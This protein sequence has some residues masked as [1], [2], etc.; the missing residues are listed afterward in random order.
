MAAAREGG[1]GDSVDGGR[2]EEEKTAALWV[3]MGGAEPE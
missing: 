1:R 2:R 3:R